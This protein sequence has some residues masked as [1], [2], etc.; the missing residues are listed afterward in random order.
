MI[1]VKVHTHGREVLVAACDED[2]LGKTFRSEERGLR[3]H[4]SESFYKGE[5]VDEETLRNRLEL[6][7]IAN[8]VGERT[9]QAAIRWGFVDP[10]NVLRIG[11]VP[12]AQMARMI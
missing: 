8:L 2:I 4:V 1:S 5:L 11:G 10:R 9:V 12:H 7:T 6:A 3:I